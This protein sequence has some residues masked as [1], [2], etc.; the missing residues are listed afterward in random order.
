L[1]LV[2]KSTT[3]SLRP[4]QNRH[5]YESVTFVTNTLSIL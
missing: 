4:M 1:T 5:K 2:M 3:L